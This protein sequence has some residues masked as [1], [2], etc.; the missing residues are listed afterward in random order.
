MRLFLIRHGNT[1]NKGET[2]VQVG[3]KTDLALTDKGL[4]QAKSL[5]EYFK[6]EGIAPKAIFSGSLLRQVQTAEIL[7]ESLN[8]NSEIQ[9]QTALQEIDYGLWEG[10]S[11]EDIKA[12]WANEY[13]AWTD[14]GVWP[15]EVFAEKEVKRIKELQ[16]LFTYLSENFK[17]TDDVILVSSN[18]I[19]RQFTRFV[20]GERNSLWE[21]LSESKEID[22]LKVRTG[23][24]SEM[25]ILDDCAEKISWNL[26]P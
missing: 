25:K 8:I 21:D 17:E 22:S 3:A 9:T 18:G 24:F 5:A 19:I 16:K 23:S 2:P 20:A 13:T 14:G 6:K 1:F 10:L 15:E 7:K 26:L 12:S 11:V 4:E